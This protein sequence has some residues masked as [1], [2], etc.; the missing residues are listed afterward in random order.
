MNCSTITTGINRKAHVIVLPDQTN[1]TNRKKT[2]T[3][4]LMSPTN[5]PAIGSNSVLKAMFFTIPE[6]PTT[7][8]VAP[9]MDSC[10]A[11]HGP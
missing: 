8:V 1:R 5:A 6:A 4:R 3:A 7:D 9:K 11:S 2:L 10:N